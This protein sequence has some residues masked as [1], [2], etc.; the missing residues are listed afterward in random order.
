M[1]ISKKRLFDIIDNFKTKRILVYGDLILDRY[2]IGDIERI[3][4]EAPV[5]I[6]KVKKEKFRP[7]GAGNV[8]LNIQSLSAKPHLIS[9]TG[10]DGFSKHFNDFFN[11]KNSNIFFNNRNKTIVK[12]RIISQNQQL[13]RIDREESVN[14]ND[15]ELKD[16]ERIIKGLNVDA[17]ILSDYSTGS[18]N[19]EILTMFKRKSKEDDI[20]LL[21][22]PKPINYS[23]YGKDFSI[24]TPNTAEAE[25]LV[26]FK[27]ISD[28]DARKA[29]KI[30]SR[31]FKTK[32]T[33]LTRGEKGITAFERGKNIFT[34]PSYSHEVYDVT[35]AG[36]TV[37]SVLL[38]SLC[39]GANL[40]E[41][42]ILSNLAASIVIERIGASQCSVEELKKRIID[43]YGK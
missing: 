23:I 11:D 19:S 17:I 37:A 36:D 6:L 20:L 16:L 25:A 14:I 7:G 18:I 34:I 29:V 22:D 8:T 27:I 43:I 26:K 21:L 35:G 10:N 38:L 33:V 41:A 24:I 40:K 42:V 4:R 15:N 39:S 13:I 1:R 30:I 32:H 12:S 5:P 2:I 28:E 3:S 31:R 9:F